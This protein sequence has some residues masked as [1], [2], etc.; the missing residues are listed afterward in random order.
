MAPGGG[1]GVRSLSGGER[2]QQPGLLPQRGPAAAPAA[3][4]PG[5]HGG[6]GGPRE[7]RRGEDTQRLGDEPQNAKH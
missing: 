1:G 5:E 4:A 3:A 7:Q 6:H 2:D